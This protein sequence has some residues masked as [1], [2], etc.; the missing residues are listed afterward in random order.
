M[1]NEKIV[2]TEPVT[3]TTLREEAS[4][5]FEEKKSVFIGHAKPAKTEEDW[6]GLSP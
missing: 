4:A 1:K 2:Q 5:E 3:C 6:Y